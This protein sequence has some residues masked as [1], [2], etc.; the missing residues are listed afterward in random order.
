MKHA[1]GYNQYVHMIKLKCKLNSLLILFN[2]TREDLGNK[3]SRKMYTVSKNRDAMYN[4][5]QFVCA[6]SLICDTQLSFS[7]QQPL[8]P[9]DL[10]RPLPF[11][12]GTHSARCAEHAEWL[13]TQ[14]QGSRQPI[15]RL[16][17]VYN[18]IEQRKTMLSLISKCLLVF[19]Y[20][21][22]NHCH[23]SHFCRG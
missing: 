19:W 5:S 1:L 8:P 20:K 23:T 12:R 10:H 13:R 17:L 21:I 15:N 3:C 4:G 16:R 7:L 18:K 22:F 11:M 9:T 6:E 14:C 2:E